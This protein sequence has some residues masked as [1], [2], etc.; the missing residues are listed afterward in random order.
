MDINSVLVLCD[1][2]VLPNKAL[3]CKEA[4][5]AFAQG[6][7]SYGQRLNFKSQHI[8]KRPLIST[9]Y[10]NGYCEPEIQENFREIFQICLGVQ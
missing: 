9:I 10:G 3:M 6:L 2:I 1:K 8:Q 7:L 5:V 4:N